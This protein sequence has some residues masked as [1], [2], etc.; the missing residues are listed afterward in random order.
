MRYAALGLWMRPVLPSR[1]DNPF[2]YAGSLERVWGALGVL[3]RSLKLLVWPWPLSLDYSYAQIVPGGV[4]NALYAAG[5]LAAVLGWGWLAW[6]WRS[7]APWLGLGL[8]L[9]LAGYLPAANLLVPIGTV[10]AERTLYLPSAGF[11]LAAV[12]SAAL[13]LVRLARGD[14]RAPAGALAAAALVLGGLTWMRN[15]EWADPFRLWER[16]A[17]VSPRS[18]RALR[19]YGQYLNRKNRFAE[20][21][22]VL[23]EAVRIYPIYDPAWIDLGIAQMQSRHEKEAEISLKE[24]LRLRSDSPEAHLALGALLSGTGRLEEAQGHLERAVALAPH[25]AEARFN[26][27]T[28]YL[29]LGHRKLAVEHLR[30]ALSLESGR[31]DAHHNLA[32]ALYL[33]GD[34]AGARRHAQE[35]ARL[36]VRLHPAMAKALGLSPASQGSGP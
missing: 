12:P 14:W 30:A 31:G 20:A 4:E 9:F 17:Q 22:P 33:E 7:E 27:G 11:L 13:G 5:G 1:L 23:R 29:K 3:G 26:L 8:V 6:R 35:A 19:N 25:F 16:A 24:A 18:A 28:L 32:I 34:E 2:A 15:R 10:M 21:I 36:G